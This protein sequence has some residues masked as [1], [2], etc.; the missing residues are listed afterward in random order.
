MEVFKCGSAYGNT[1]CKSIGGIGMADDVQGKDRR[2]KIV[3]LSEEAVAKFPEI[4][5]FNNSV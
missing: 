2:E 1:D 3:R 5:D 4:E